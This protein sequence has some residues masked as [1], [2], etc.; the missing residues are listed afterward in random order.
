MG[1][2]TTTLCKPLSRTGCRTACKLPPAFTWQHT[3]GFGGLNGAVEDPYHPQLSLGSIGSPL[4]FTVTGTYYI[5]NIKAPA[6][7]LQGWEVN[8]TVY[9]LSGPVA[10]ANDSADDL[11]GDGQSVNWDIVGNPRSFK[12][13]SVG[14]PVPC[15]GI[16]GSSFSKATNC[17]TVATLAQM[18][19]VCMSGA[20]AAPI[21]P[22]VG[23]SA[24]FEL[25]KLGCYVT[26]NPNAL[27]SSALFPNAPGTFGNEGFGTMHGHGFRNLDFSILKNWKF[28][29]RYGVQ[30]RAE[31]F[32]VFNRTLIFG[33]GG[34]AANTPATFGQIT[35]TTDSTN[36]VIG[37]GVRKIQLGL[38]LSF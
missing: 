15:Y 22:S 37:N 13:G 35:N 10:P 34:T 12:L 11:A 31:F 28:K 19:A 29:E 33:A 16:A 8:G 9:M 27:T 38:K 18:P 30:F 20:A 36:P 2:P 32:N 7:L 4:D 21:N 1:T 26:G 6:Q 3:L 14:H 25:G 17:T 24:T 23:T 5:P